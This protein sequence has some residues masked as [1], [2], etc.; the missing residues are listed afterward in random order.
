MR[1]YRVNYFAMSNEEQSTEWTTSM[2]AAEKIARDNRCGD[3]E[4]TIIAVDIPTDKT[5]LLSFLNENIMSHSEATI[6]WN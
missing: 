4:P 3:Y 2:A 5:G 6:P 1:F